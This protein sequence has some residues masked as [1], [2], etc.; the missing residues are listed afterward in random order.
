MHQFELQSL[1]L[2]DIID[3]AIMHPV[4]T[5]DDITSILKQ[6]ITKNHSGSSDNLSYL[7]HIMNWLVQENHVA[8]TLGQVNK[9]FDASKYDLKAAYKQCTLELW[10]DYYASKKPT[11]TILDPWSDYCASQKHM[12]DIGLDNE[13]PTT[14]KI[15][16]FYDADGLPRYM[17]L[18]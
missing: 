13:P 11:T 6:V 15:Q 10:D 1:L 9:K 12:T 18:E 3:T 2:K 16:I 8:W 5:Q 17:P 14:R 4:Q 7:M